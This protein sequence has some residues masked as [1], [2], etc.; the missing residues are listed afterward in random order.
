[1]VLCFGAAL[2]AQ[3][4][5]GELDNRIEGLIPSYFTSTGHPYLLLFMWEDG[6]DILRVLA[7]DFVTTVADIDVESIE[8]HI[9]E[10]DY[11]DLD[12]FNEELELVFTQNLFNDDPF[13]EYFERERELTTHNDTIWEYNYEENLPYYV[14]TWSEWRTTVIR[15]KSTNGSTVWEYIP[16]EGIDCELEAILKFDNKFY[17]VIREEDEEGVKNQLYLIKQNQGVTKVETPSPLKVFPTL[18]DRSQQITVEL[19]EGNNAKEVI[20][21]NNMGQVVKQVPVE[22]GQR[23]VTFPARE[24]R[25]L[26]VV[27]TR[28]SK[29]P[30]SCKIIV[31]YRSEHQA[32]KT[33]PRKRNS[34]GDF[35]SRPRD[36]TARAT[37]SL[38]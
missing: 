31:Q 13:F 21:V 27:H 11:V 26:N 1:M 29:G 35:T 34:Y 33:N 38:A 18:L 23:T 8:D 32:K 28:T 14:Y 17:M 6:N 9:F 25:G 22:Q 2:K 10:V 4:Y 30:G 24:L 16:D 36:N 3:T 20:V 37:A 5:V 12:A 7:S 15:I 19:G